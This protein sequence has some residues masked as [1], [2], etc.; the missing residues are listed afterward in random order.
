MVTIRS[1]LLIFLQDL[2]IILLTGPP[3]PL[4]LLR[5]VSQWGTFFYEDIIMEVKKPTTFEEQLNKQA[6]TE[7]FFADFF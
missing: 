5:D 4:R 2:H 6:L 3:A 7:R 1:V